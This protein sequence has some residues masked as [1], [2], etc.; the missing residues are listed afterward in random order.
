LVPT[1]HL[2]IVQ[3]MEHFL[4]CDSRGASSIGVGTVWRERMPAV[5]GIVCRLEEKSRGQGMGD[6]L[7]LDLRID[8]V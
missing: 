8:T 7:G 6:Y 4:K 3:V 5:A 1:R 2:I